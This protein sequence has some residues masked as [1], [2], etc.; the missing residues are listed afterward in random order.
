MLAPGE[1]K[2][3]VLNFGRGALLAV[4]TVNSPGDHMAA[5]K[6]L[7]SGS[8]VSED[9]LAQSDNDLRRA[10]KAIGA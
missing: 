4:E 10:L 1:G 2:T 9:M 3:V 7:A 5:R 6:L 8:P